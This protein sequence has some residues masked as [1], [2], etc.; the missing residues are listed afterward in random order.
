MT[1]EMTRGAPLGGMLPD[2]RIGAGRQLVALDLD[3]TTLRHDGTLRDPVAQAVRHTVAAGHEVVVATGRS[4]TSALPV[5]EA[6]GLDRGYAVCSNGAV[7]LRL[8]GGDAQILDRHTFHPRPVLSQLRAAFPAGA[9]AVER[10][11]VG[12]DVSRPFPPGEL[13]GRVRIVPWHRLVQ[14]PTTRVTFCDPDTDVEVFAGHVGTLGLQEVNY[15]VGYTAW[16]DITALGVSKA[17]GLEAVRRRVGVDPQATVA[18]GDQRN[19]LEML[20]WAGCGVAMGNAP[21]EVSAVADFVTG[22][23]DD[24]G[25]VDVLRRLPLL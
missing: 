17:S 22:H 1:V 3:G 8:D 15:A 20:A 11:G 2:F 7:T 10:V 23:V 19:D 16:L 12:F 24:D 5:I 18:V 4:M 13:T 14:R 21:A 25:L 9:L 6:L